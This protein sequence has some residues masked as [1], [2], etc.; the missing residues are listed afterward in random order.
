M[1]RH[2][3]RALAEIAVSQRALDG[4][5]I[6]AARALLKEWSRPEHLLGFRESE[7][8]TARAVLTEALQKRDAH[9]LRQSETNKARRGR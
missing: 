2:P 3:G 9:L 6:Q 4:E 1:S 7:L 5:V 8:R